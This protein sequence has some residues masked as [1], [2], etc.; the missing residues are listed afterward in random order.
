MEVLTLPI[1]KTSTCSTLPSST[2]DVTAFYPLDEPGLTATGRYLDADQAIIECRLNEPD[3]WCRRCGP[4]SN[5]RDTVTRKLAHEPFGHRPATLLVRMRGSAVG[6][7]DSC[8]L[9]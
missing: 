2:P 3:P 6:L 1:R 9:A 7:I 8:P 5:P 4:W